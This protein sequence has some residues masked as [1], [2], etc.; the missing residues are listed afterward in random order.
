M[1]IE[2]DYHRAEAMIAQCLIS[3]AKEPPQASNIESRQQC[4][5]PIISS[6]SLAENEQ[7]NTRSKESRRYKYLGDKYQIPAL[8]L[9]DP[10]QWECEQNQSASSG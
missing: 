9:P 1:D 5:D 8:D 4:E 2:A 3:M 7:S 10:N 6:S